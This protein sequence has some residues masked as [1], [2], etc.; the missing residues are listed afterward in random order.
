M[1]ASVGQLWQ[2]STHHCMK[3]AEFLSQLLCKLREYKH[4]E[5]EVSKERE[6]AEAVRM[7]SG[8]YEGGRYSLLL[9]KSNTSAYVNGQT[10]YLLYSSSKN[11]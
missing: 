1:E 7:L 9:L 8:V 6:K 2:V 10:D 3:G 11:T 4:G 5:T